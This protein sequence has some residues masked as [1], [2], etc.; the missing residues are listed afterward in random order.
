M[1]MYVGPGTKHQGTQTD[2]GETD[3]EG[4]LAIS[5]INMEETM[6]LWG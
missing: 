6:K 5:R 3:N 4:I 2:P 1:Y